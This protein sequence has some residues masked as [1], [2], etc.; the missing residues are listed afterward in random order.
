MIIKLELI[1]V[2]LLH[3]VKLYTQN[4]Y[5]TAYGNIGLP[6]MIREINETNYRKSSLAIAAL[7]DDLYD[8]ENCFR[9]INL[10]IIKRYSNKLAKNNDFE[11]LNNIC[12][13]LKIISTQLQGAQ[14]IIEED[15]IM[16]KLYNLINADDVILKN[17][18]ADV[19]LRLASHFESIYSF[20]F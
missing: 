11:N 3:T 4:F 9:A 8:D 6:K 19:L 18:S 13:G 5:F 2:T 17:S 20:K 16:K 1:Q 15:V 12:L 7:K 14:K 10:H